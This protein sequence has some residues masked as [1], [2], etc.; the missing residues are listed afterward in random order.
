MKSLPNVNLKP[1][2]FHGEWKLHD[3]S[4]QLTQVVNVIYLRLLKAVAVGPLFQISKMHG[5]GNS[6]FI[7]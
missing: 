1:N 5:L 7:E 3:T 6:P 4:S 2:K